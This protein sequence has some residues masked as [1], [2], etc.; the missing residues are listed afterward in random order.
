MKK[1]LVLLLTLSLILTFASCNKNENNTAAGKSA[2]AVNEEPP[3]EPMET[4]ESISIGLE[5][6]QEGAAA[7]SD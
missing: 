4:V 6:G 5:E 1:Y 3:A 2:E 7:P